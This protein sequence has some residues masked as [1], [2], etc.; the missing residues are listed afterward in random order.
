MDWTILYDA[1]IAL[2][3]L[4]GIVVTAINWAGVR[5]LDKMKPR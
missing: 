1:F 5:A 2:L 4:A 3:I